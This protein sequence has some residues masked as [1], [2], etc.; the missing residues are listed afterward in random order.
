[1]SEEDEDNSVPFV[2]H[3]EGWERI[4][5]SR[6][7]LL[8]RCNTIVDFVTMP[9]YLVFGEDVLRKVGWDMERSVAF[10][11]PDIVKD[12]RGEVDRLR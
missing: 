10:Y 11:R 7:Q 2:F 4:W 3:T 9:K 8:V 5:D 6:H 1:M 12:A